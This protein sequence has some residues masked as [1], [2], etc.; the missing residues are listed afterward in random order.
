LIYE[1]K[2]D[3]KDSKTDLKQQKTHLQFLTA[4]LASE[5]LFEILR[6]A[7]ILA[8]VKISGFPS[9]YESM[10]TPISIVNQ[11]KRRT[12]PESACGNVPTLPFYSRYPPPPG[13]KI[14]YY[15]GNVNALPLMLVLFLLFNISLCCLS[16]PVLLR[17][18]LFY[19]S[20]LPLFMPPILYNLSP[21]AF[22]FLLAL[23]AV[24]D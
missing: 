2:Q 9:P 6:G 11:K 8:F 1:K 14:T 23:A 16:S 22:S 24:G 20:S 10:R 5:Q 17:C 18:V 19:G 15:Y 13:C 21:G 7:E 3:Q 4:L 12:N